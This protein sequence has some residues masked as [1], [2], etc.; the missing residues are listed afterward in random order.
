MTNFSLVINFRKLY[1]MAS[2]DDT[3]EARAFQE[4]YSTLVN[5]IQDPDTIADQLFSKRI[6]SREVLVGLQTPG[7]SNL[8]KNRRILQCVFNRIV[9][10]DPSSFWVFTDVL[11]C[12]AYTEPLSHKLEASC[13]ELYYQ[14]YKCAMSCRCMDTSQCCIVQSKQDLLMNPLTTVQVTDSLVFFISLL[15][16]SQIRYSLDIMSPLFVNRRFSV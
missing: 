1:T 10:V 6:L 9:F 8:V 4:H 14:T 7:L 2:N 3:P 15:N 12:E 5:V 13:C 16:Y 11:K